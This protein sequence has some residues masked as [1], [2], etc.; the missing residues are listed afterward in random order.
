M[1]TKQ[2]LR[3]ASNIL[4]WMVFGLAL[5]TVILSFNDAEGIPNIFGVGYLSVQSN[6]MEGE[7]GFSKGDLIIV[8]T[9]KINDLFEEGDI[10]TFRTIIGGKPALNTHRI[11]DYV[12][13]GPQRYY[14]TQGDNVEEPDILTITS[15]DIVAKYIDKVSKIGNVVDYIQ[16]DS[17]FL[18][19][20]VIPLAA[21]FIY[22]LVNFAMLMAKYKEGDKKPVSVDTLTDEQKEEIARKY[23]ESLNAKK[24]NM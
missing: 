22:Q 13:I 9:T 2:V 14:T 6:S 23:L 24:D 1:K 19:T 18:I 21:I 8:R 12:E 4:I 16:S 7:N 10:V 5:L 11:I 15:N 17:G 20:I 3:I